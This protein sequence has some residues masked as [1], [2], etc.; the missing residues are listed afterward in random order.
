MAQPFMILRSFLDLGSKLNLKQV[1]IMKK[2]LF[3]IAMM[4]TLL[5]AGCAKENLA[6]PETPAGVQEGTTVLTA[7]VAPSVKT[8]LQNDA[9]VLWTNGDKI[10]V[11]GEESAALEL[12]EAAATATF[13]FPESVLSDPYKA[14]FPAS[15]YKNENTVTLP[16]YQTYEAGSFSAT[17]SP[18]AAVSAT[19]SLKFSHLCAVL[20]LT[21]NAGE[22]HNSIE[23][24]DF[25]AKGGEQISGDFTLDY[26]TLSLT[27]ASTA[28][29]DKK[30]RYKVSKTLGEEPFVMYLVVP[31]QAYTEGYTVKLLDKEGHFMEQSRKSAQTLVAG[32]IYDM[33][34]FDFVPTGTELGVEIATAQDLIDFA[35]AYNAGE[36]ADEDL[37]V[38][39]LTQD[40]TFD[41][42]TSAA[43]A[44]TGG[45]GNKTGDVTNYFNGVFNGAGKVIS[46]YAAGVPLFAFTGSGSIIKDLTLADDC[47]LTVA[48]PA[49]VQNHGPLVG[50]NKGLV[51]NCTSHASVVIENL[52]DVNEA[53][54]QYGGLV[55]RNYGGT[56][57]D[58]VV[59]GDITCSQSNVAITV[60]ANQTQ[61]IVIG[62]VAGSQGDNGSISGCDFQG[63]ITVSDGTDFGG[64]VS[65]QTNAAGSGYFYAGGIVG[66]FENGMVSD[67]AA[68]LESE[69]RTITARGSFAPLIGGIAAEAAGN[70]S[71]IKNCTNRM[72]FD[73]KS[74]G[75]RDVTT[76]CVV[77]GIAG[78]SD[79]DISNCQ[80]YGPIATVC[81]STRIYLAGIVGQGGNVSY[82]TNKGAITRTNQLSNIQ[83]NRYIYIGGIMGETRSAC[84]VDHCTNE[85][86]IESAK[87]TRSSSNATLDMGGIVGYGGKQVDISNCVNSGYVHAVAETD[88]TFT[89]TNMGGVLGYG[90]IAST[91]ITGCDNSGYIYLQ[92]N[93]KRRNG[94]VSY[95]GGIAGQMG[96]V[97]GVAGLEIKN[98]DNTGRVWVRNNNNTVKLKGGPFGSCIV[99]AIFG[100]AES[101]ALV[102]GCTASGDQQ[103]QSYRGICGGIAGYAGNAVLTSNTM[104]QTFNSNQNATGNG[105]IVGWMVASEMI[106]C[107]FAGSMPNSLDGE[108]VGT[109]NT[110]GLVYLMDGTSS[111]ENCK[112]NGATIVTGAYV[113]A[114]TGE[115]A[116]A[117][118][119]L[120]SNAAAGATIT[121]CGVKGTLDGA[122]ITLES[123]MITTDGGATVTGT[124]LLE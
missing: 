41:A 120:V 42:E 78:R 123:N 119:V 45:I 4:A 104:S 47:V 3:P 24:V 39:T 55:G 57:E 97:A 9:Q 107:T 31:A 101:K 92:Y 114:D 5:V 8:V 73:F 109:K 116:T 18:M 53:T 121:N 40:I 96:P 37:L 91:T 100:T 75:A 83:S 6:E 13:N 72:S 23:Y 17:A 66:D 50:R 105:G 111:I 26:E 58:C 20:K 112:V 77:A 88:S 1:S 68:G 48:S 62:G 84:D 35:K 82:C 28:D 49:T 54:Q 21:V 14:V 27:G 102:S 16:A 33:Q 19:A 115:T 52:A 65:T 43:Y 61:R 113:N 124:Y 99:G 106:D 22:E 63:N 86:A 64:I 34:A 67:C 80:N 110:G 108:S 94:R 2:I 7:V 69:T 46:A 56:I 51:K 117:A 10:N 122:A 79:A 98:C 59:T 60:D 11:N 85:A 25:Y 103:C 74:D 15:I 44:A 95:I 70:D 118:A 36:Y 29:A 71:E 90:S 12:E 89:R 76:P 81:N 93:N 30:V 87:I 38:A 32:K